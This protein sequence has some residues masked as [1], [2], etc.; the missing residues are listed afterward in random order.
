MSNGINQ[1]YNDFFYAVFSDK[2]GL[3]YALYFQTALHL[4]YYH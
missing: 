1:V 2:E 4:E 3:H